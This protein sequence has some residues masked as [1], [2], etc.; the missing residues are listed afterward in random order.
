MRYV[1]GHSSRGADATERVLRDAVSEYLTGELGT[2]MIPVDTLAAYA[3]LPVLRD[4]VGA[5]VALWQDG[6]WWTRAEWAE[7]DADTA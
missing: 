1:F 3:V 6:R 5:I 7:Y 2:V 4:P